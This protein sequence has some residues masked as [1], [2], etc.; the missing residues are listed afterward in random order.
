MRKAGVTIRFWGVR[1]SVPCPGP[2]T[3]RYGGNTA[4]VELRCGDDLIIL[5]GGTGLVPLGRNLAATG[6]PISADILY[7]HTHIDHVQGLPFFA[8]ARQDGTSLRLWA[9]HLDGVPLEQVLLTLF[10]PP[11]LPLKPHEFGAHF[12]YRDFR[13]GDT[14]A[15]R[16]GVTV[17]TAPLQHPDGATGYRVEHGGKAVAYITDTE[18]SGAGLDPAVLELAAGADLMIYDSTYDDREFARQVGCGHSTWQE[19][20]RLAKAADV[21]RVALFHHDPAKDDDALDAIEQKAAS[22]F[23][24]ALMAREGMMLEA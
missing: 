22:M 19:A 14:L 10:S 20:L 4:C 1:G 21:R 6:R 12:E 7:T 9:G 15:P 24:G 16:P 18:H 3:V 5:D 2:R 8:P 11:L 23:A 13:A 17:R